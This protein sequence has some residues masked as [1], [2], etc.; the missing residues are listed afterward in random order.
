MKTIKKIYFYLKTHLNKYW[1]AGIIA[2]VLTFLVGESSIFNR[3]SYDRQIRQLTKEIE[4]HTKQKEENEQRLRAL[5]NDN[6]GLE[7]LAREKYLMTKP[8]E[9]LFIIEE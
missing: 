9:E 6:E 7:R 3:F 2:V 5:Q 1:I 8:N 4:I